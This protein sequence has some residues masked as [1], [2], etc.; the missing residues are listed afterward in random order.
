MSRSPRRA[1]PPRP[2]SS[3]SRPT[4]RA[5]WAAPAC[6]RTRPRGARWQAPPPAPSRLL[7]RSSR[8]LPFTRTCLVVI[9]ILGDG[10]SSYLEA[11]PGLIPAF[12]T[13]SFPGLS[14]SSAWDRYTNFLDTTSRI[15]T[16]PKPNKRCRSTARASA[17]TNGDSRRS[18]HET[19]NYASRN[20]L[21]EFMFISIP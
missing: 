2:T 13:R 5:A 1:G 20:T 3:R 21:Q 6:S 4:R 15:L 7:C 19:S 16:V 14:S 11:S 12:P 17:H 10:R 8:S 18:R 9:Q